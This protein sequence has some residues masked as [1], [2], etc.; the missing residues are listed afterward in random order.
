MSGKRLRETSF[1]SGDGQD[2]LNSSKGH[3]KSEDSSDDSETELLGRVNSGAAASSSAPS[4]SKSESRS[5]SVPTFEE[6]HRRLKEFPEYNLHL[7]PKHFLSTGLDMLVIQERCN[8]LDIYLKNSKLKLSALMGRE[9]E[10]KKAHLIK[11]E[12]ICEDKSKGGL[13]LRKLVFLN[14][15]LLGKWVWRFAIDRDDLWKQVIV[16][17][18]GQEGLGWRAKKAYGTIGVGVWKEIWKES[19]WLAQSFPHLYAMASHRNATVEEMWDQNFGQGGW[20][21]RFL[22]DFNDWEMEMIGKLLHVLR[23]FKPS[24]GGRLSPLEGRKECSNQVAFYAWEATWGRVLTLDRLQKEDGNFLTAAF[25]VW[26]FPETVKEVLTS[27]RGPFVGKKRK[28]YG[29]PFRCVFFG[30]FGRKEIGSIEVWD[31]LSVDSQTYIFSNSISIIETLSVDLH[32]KP[33]ENSN[34][35][36]S[37]VGPLVNPLPSR[38]AH[39]G[40]ESKEPPLQTKHNHLVDQGR[41]TEKGTTYS[42]VEKPVKECGKPFDDS[43]SDSDSRVQKNA[44]STGNL[45]KK[46]KGREG[47]GLLE[48]LR[49]FLMLKMTH[50]FLQRRKAFWVAKQLLRKG[51]VIAS[52]IKRI[53]KFSCDFKQ[54]LW[55][56]GIFLTKHPKRRRPSVP[57]SPSQMSPHGQQ[58]AQMSSPKKEDLQKLQEKEHNLVLD[59]LQQ[60]EADRRAKLVYELMI[61]NPPSAIVGLVGRKEYEQCAK[62]L[63]FFLQS[64]VCLKMLAFDLLELLVLSAFPEL[65][66]IFKQ[67]FEERQKFGEFKPN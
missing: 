19:N 27:W 44:S 67:L 40:T 26:V 47:D 48:H 43:G 55:P 20:N 15:A 32:C 37:F 59:E 33:A 31:F 45:G 5:F 63:Y 22:R 8:L 25:Y 64:S 46:V 60:Q 4:I 54:I 49:C 66:D 29:N 3:E 38:R 42:L 35:V 39:L 11:W 23:D 14:K 17:K 34:K 50:P 30:R 6:L 13:G 65:D 36:L 24:M 62:D 7:P 21:L 10:E 12:A 9:S 18:Y 28:R 61:D 56:D 52:G 2:I 58:P 16:A 51:S 53:E 57:M 1:L 41:L